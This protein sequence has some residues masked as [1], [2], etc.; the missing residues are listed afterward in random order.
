MFH[1][2]N[3]QYVVKQEYNPLN[4]LYFCPSQHHFNSCQKFS[5]ALFLD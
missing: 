1:E 2:L 3:D 5:M 4:T